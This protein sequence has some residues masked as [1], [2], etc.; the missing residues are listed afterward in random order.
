[1][2]GKAYKRGYEHTKG[3]GKETTVTCG[4]CGRQAPKYKCIPVFKGFR[5]NDPLVRKEL[6]NKGMGFTSSKV[7]ACPACS[8][9]RKITKKKTGPRTR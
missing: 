7:Y 5:I 2:A 6:G 4:F 3:R 1:M 9:H 8:R